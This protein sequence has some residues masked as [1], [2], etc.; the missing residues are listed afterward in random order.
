[1]ALPKID[2]KYGLATD[3]FTTFGHK[4]S[5]ID[6]A[7]RE[8]EQLT[9]IDPV[10]DGIKASLISDTVQSNK[11]KDFLVW[12]DKMEKFMPAN[13]SFVELWPELNTLLSN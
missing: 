13:K 3:S 11:D 5:I 6:R 1:M 10:V 12:T 8:I 2:N 4:K 7:I 9:I